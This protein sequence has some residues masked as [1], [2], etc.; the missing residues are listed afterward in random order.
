MYLKNLSC[1]SPKVY[2]SDPDLKKAQ[3]SALQRELEKSWSFISKEK[4]FL[5]HCRKH[6][7]A[8]QVHTQKNFN[9]SSAQACLT[10]C[11]AYLAC[12]DHLL[13]SILYLQP[14]LGG[15]PIDGW[16]LSRPTSYRQVF[17]V[18]GCTT[19]QWKTDFGSA[20][21]YLFDIYFVQEQF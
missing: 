20:S 13:S 7:S 19:A 11:L 5:P 4:P 3:C 17:Q 16:P 1:Q 8:A 9:P 14:V 18:T 6:S 15:L 12:C 2:E 21:P 10:C